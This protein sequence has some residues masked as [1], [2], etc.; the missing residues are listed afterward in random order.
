[1]SQTQ[2]PC[3][4]ISHQAEKMT[5]CV[6]SNYPVSFVRVVLWMKV[7]AN[8]T[9][10][11]KPAYRITVLWFPMLQK[12]GEQAL[13]QV[14]SLPRCPQRKNTNNLLPNDINDTTALCGAR[15]VCCL[16]NWWK[17]AGAIYSEREDFNRIITL[18]FGLTSHLYS[19]LYLSFR[20]NFNH[21]CRMLIMDV[22]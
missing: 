20:E 2:A 11:C 9:T 7:E 10:S 12:V 22:V 19:K 4:K 14:K 8:V 3:K 6:F 16:A 15:V 1:M 21:L 5:P 18:H 17:T 13:K